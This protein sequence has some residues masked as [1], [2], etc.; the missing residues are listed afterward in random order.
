MRVTLKFSGEDLY[1][2]RDEQTKVINSRGRGVPSGAEAR[3][4][5]GDS[6]SRNS[7]M[8]LDGSAIEEESLN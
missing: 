1:S 8:N 5:I 3:G 6:V 4:M 7:F 2:E